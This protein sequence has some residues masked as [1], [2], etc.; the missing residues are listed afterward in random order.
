MKKFIQQLYNPFI[1]ML[2]I[3]WIIAT[4]AYFN[5]RYETL[6][7]QQAQKQETLAI[8]HKFVGEFSVS[9]YCSCPKCTGTPKG[10]RTATGHIPREGRT[11]AVD[12]KLIPLH[13]VIFVEGLGTYVAED[14]GGAV[15]GRHLDIYVSDHQKALNLGTLGGKK[16]KVYVL[17]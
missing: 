12:K 2:M 13:S 11:V 4:Y 15:K 10:S 14:V 1:I 6:K 5:M 8:P 17:E 3:V 9:Y 7:E 16:F